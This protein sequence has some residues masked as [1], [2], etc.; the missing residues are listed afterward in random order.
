[1][2]AL[3]IEWLQLPLRSACVMH[4]ALLTLFM[5][6]NLVLWNDLQVLRDDLKKQE[7]RFDHLDRLRLHVMLLEQRNLELEA[8]RAP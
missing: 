6:E 2:D 8:K 4:G 1:M 5:I 7:D 3:A